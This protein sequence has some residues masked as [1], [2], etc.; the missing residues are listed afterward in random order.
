MGCFS[1]RTAPRVGRGLMQR[2]CWRCAARG[3]CVPGCC[4]WR[5]S[6]APVLRQVPRSS[7]SEDRLSPPCPGM[8]GGS[9]GT[10][11]PP[12]GSAVCAFPRGWGRGAWKWQPSHRCCWVTRAGDASPVNKFHLGTSHRPC[13]R[14]L[15]TTVEHRVRQRQR[16][17][18]SRRL[19]TAS[20][21]VLQRWEM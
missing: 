2:G 15:V 16:V 5:P 18:S 8:A 7:A 6:N 20:V 17:I 21:S 13:T 3:Q 10:E 14:G 19:T 4:P 1:P 12:R 11:T 9:P